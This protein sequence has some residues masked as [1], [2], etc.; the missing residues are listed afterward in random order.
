MGKKSKSKSD[1]KKDDSIPYEMSPDEY[2]ELEQQ[3]ADLTLD[4]AKE[5]L[6]ECARYGDLDPVR[7][8]LGKFG[9]EIVDCTDEETQTTALH[10]ASANGH[11]LVVRLLLQHKAKFVSNASGNTPL[12]WAAANGHEKVIKILM[13]FFDGD[14]IDVLLKNQFG[15]S[16]LTEGFASQS[17]ETAKLLLEHDSASEEKLLMG[18]KEVDAVDGEL[19]KKRDQSITHDLCFASKTNIKIRELPIAQS[20]DDNPLG[21]TPVDDTTGYGIWCASL[22]MA[23]WLA[24]IPLK[25][26]RVLELGAGCGVPGIALAKAC[27]SVKLVTTDLNP[28][29]VDNLRHNVELNDLQESTAS[30]I[31]WDDQSTWP[32]TKLDVLIGCDLIYQKS[33]VPFL[34]KVVLG[35][36]ESGAPFYYVAPDSGRDG[37][38]YFIEEMKE[39]LTLVSCQK[40]PA[41]YYSN[42]LASG[43]EEDCFLHFNEL[44]SSTFML[45]EFQR[46]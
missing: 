43:D 25:H 46:K 6:L 30:T 38:D 35:L 11:E 2:K 5:E 29:T 37:L 20:D 32:T 17:T 9:G 41:E 13:D 16:A 19:K 14:Q 23:H 33:I 7:A 34:K 8:L 31:D 24:T 3:V 36:L 28:T 44:G 4:E 12:H 18:G 15:R 39:S 10:R 27:P 21:D 22:V 42:P 1:K 26:K 40:A 45:Y